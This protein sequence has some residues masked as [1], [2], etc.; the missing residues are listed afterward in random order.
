MTG[1]LVLCEIR[2]DGDRELARIERGEVVIGREPQEGVAVP[3]SAISREHG[4][5]FRIRSHW[6]YRDL[7]STNGS[8]ING[9]VVNPNSTRL[10]RPGD[11][12]QLADTPVRVGPDENSQHAS[13]LESLSAFH[14]STLIVFRKDEFL[15]EYPL[16]EYGR[17][18]VIGGSQADLSLEPETSDLPR[19]VIERRGEQVCAYGISDGP[20]IILNE[21]PVTENAT[22][23]DGDELTVAEYLILFNDPRG[24]QEIST[25]TADGAVNPAGLHQPA[26][27]QVD[28]V[29][30]AGRA[31]AGN[32]Q[33]SSP[34]GISN[35]GRFTFGQPTFDDENGE[36]PV[37]LEGTM[38]MDPAEIEARLAGY[39][40]HPSTRRH[41][42][43]ASDSYSGP[44][45]SIETR[46][47]VLVWFLLLMVLVGAVVWWGFLY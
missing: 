14:S 5:F 8:W 17:A 47:A 45:Q 31:G 36:N 44:F 11:V 38:A 12:M 10:V 21:T 39:D 7:G 27:P 22:L 35:S 15:D 25:S 1:Q 33:S 43:T 23:S 29:G 34:Y 40:T 46:I 3:N 6:F 13:E 37:D 41:L 4:I 24:S 20:D 26:A 9:K 16:P 32:E 2:D 28:L 42:S 18:L 30:S 19:L